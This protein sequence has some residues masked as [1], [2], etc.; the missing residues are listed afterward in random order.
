M[1]RKVRRVRPT[2]SGTKAA[3][4]AKEKATAKPKLSPEE[5]FRQEYAYVLKD[6]RQVLILAIAMFA[7]LIVLNVVLR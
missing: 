2:Q 6:L 7:L 3:D 5:Q 4:T 1:A